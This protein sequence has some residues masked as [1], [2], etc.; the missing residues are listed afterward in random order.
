MPNVS[1]DLDP[2]ST[3]WER[4]PDAYRHQ[5]GAHKGTP[6]RSVLTGQLMVIDRSGLIHNLDAENVHRW[7]VISSYE[8]GPRE[9]AIEYTD[10]RAER[11]ECAEPVTHPGSGCEDCEF[12]G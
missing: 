1:Q 10:G 11:V 8:H 9:I 4:G 7:T 3:R 2:K 5:P 6:I 12:C